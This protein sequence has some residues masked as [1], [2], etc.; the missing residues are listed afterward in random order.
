MK[1]CKWFD[2]SRGEPAAAETSTAESVEPRPGTETQNSVQSPAMAACPRNS[3]VVNGCKIEQSTRP[4]PGFQAFFKKQDLGFGKSASPPT[5]TRKHCARSSHPHAA[6]IRAM[7]P[8]RTLAPTT[9]LTPARE[10]PAKEIHQSL[11]S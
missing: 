4:R 2:D 6:C 3:I 9:T 10:V 8:L 1:R 7:Q 5:A 11:H